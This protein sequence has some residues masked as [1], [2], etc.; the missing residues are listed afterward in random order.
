MKINKDYFALT[1]LTGRI[2]YFLNQGKV[3][4]HTIDRIKW[5]IF[6]KLFITP[7]FPTHIDIETSSACQLQCPM[8]GQRLMDNKMRGIMEFNLFKKIVDECKKYGVYSIK[9]SW[10]GEPLLNPNIWRMVRYAKDK[11]IKDV[12]FLTNGEALKESDLEELIE[13]GLDWISFSID[14]LYD[15]YEKIRYPSKFNEIVS[16]LK[17]LKELKKKKKRNKPLVRVQ[18]IFSA[19]KDNPEEYFNFWNDIVDRVNFIA[20]ERRAD[21]EKNFPQDPNYI[22]PMPW[23]RMVIAYNGKVAQCI[24]DYLMKNPLGDVNEKS[25]YEI[26]HDKPFKELRYLQKTKQRILLQPCKECCSGGKTREKE[27]KI[28]KKRIKIIEY[29]NQSLNVEDF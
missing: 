16:K 14:G 20:D 26:W 25:L 13:S 18:T 3:I 1:P 6:P 23:Q 10:R 17:K 12:A 5:H 19:I 4:S 2:K 29:I 11:D 9:L 8:C 21:K 7:R 24:S 22:C 15:T 28:G 27:I